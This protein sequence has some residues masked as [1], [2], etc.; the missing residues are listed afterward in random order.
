[1]LAARAESGNP[2]RVGLIG[3]G[4]FGAMF[5]SQAR[6]VQGLHVLGIADLHA[7]CSHLAW[8]LAA[9]NGVYPLLGVHAIWH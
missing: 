2:L 3:A 6:L 1:M 5:L 8:L 9:P 4:R 7:L